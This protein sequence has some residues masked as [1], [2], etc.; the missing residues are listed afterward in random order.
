M[1]ARR[2]GHV[3]AA[4]GA[5]AALPHRHPALHRFR[6]LPDAQAA[7]RRPVWLRVHLHAERD[8]GH[9]GAFR[10]RAGGAREPECAFQ[11]HV[12]ERHPHEC[13]HCLDQ[14]HRPAR[15]HDARRCCLGVQRCVHAGR[16][17][18]RGHL[19]LQGLRSER[20]RAHGGTRRRGDTSPVQR[21]P[22]RGRVDGGLQQAAGCR[23]RPARLRRRHLVP[24]HARAAADDEAL[25]RRVHR[26]LVVRAVHQVPRADGAHA[27]AR[28]ERPRHRC[29][30]RLRRHRAERRLPVPLHRQ[31][32][33]QRCGLHRVGVHDAHGRHGAA[34]VVDLHR[35]PRDALQLHHRPHFRHLAPPAVGHLHRDSARA[36]DH[37]LHHARRRHVS[38]QPGHRRGAVR[39]R[40]AHHV[41]PHAPEDAARYT[42][43]RWAARLLP[44]RRHLRRCAAPVHPCV[45]RR[46]DDGGGLHGAQHRP[47]H[48]DRGA[49]AN[50]GRWQRPG[51]GVVD[52]A[53]RAS[54]RA[55]VGGWARCRRR[56]RHRRHVHDQR[57]ERPPQ[58]G[59]GGRGG[60]QR[61]QRRG[62]GLPQGLPFPAPV[63][64]RVVCAG[65]G[66]GRHGGAT[67]RRGGRGRRR[68]RGARPRAG[69][70][71]SRHPYFRDQG[72]VADSRRHPPRHRR[73]RPPR[74][75][76][77]A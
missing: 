2:G 19:Q 37:R 49:W 10:S 33:G 57:A 1:G 53:V 45:V 11:R 61:Q 28:H 12:G 18:Y 31:P 23:P 65:G 14:V 75:C 32:Q 63:H 39:R 60:A 52:R 35:V 77:G 21:G 50:G 27:V 8:V 22:H 69:G 6:I 71:H 72:A 34:A 40:R 70:V 58:R 15:Q 13:R 7:R 55:A 73:F 54:R 17:A 3:A 64:L 20:L 76:Q 24:V 5:Y 74:C 66:A 56:R 30:H 44:L 29:L 62:G 47:G 4:G 26:R 43:A 36:V 25:R 41:P 46:R 42:A 68:R 38:R 51:L 48:V 67:Y 9:Q 16:R 59:C